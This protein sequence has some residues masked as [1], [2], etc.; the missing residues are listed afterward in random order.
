VQTVIR[1]SYALVVGLYRNGITLPP[2]LHRI[3]T[4]NVVCCVQVPKDESSQR[5]SSQN[6]RHA[7][8]PAR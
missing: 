3:S 8:S 1:L 7:A 5:A 4:L 6:A 2:R